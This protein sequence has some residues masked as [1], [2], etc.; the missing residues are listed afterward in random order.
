M[1]YIDYI[2]YLK[3]KNIIMFDHD[4]RISYGA[5]NT[6]LPYTNM[7]NHMTGGGNMLAR[8]NTDE[9]RNII[10]IATSANPQYLICVMQN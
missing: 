1:K 2:N 8:Y 7:R 9:L 10:N 6:Y 3:S 4:Y 5:I